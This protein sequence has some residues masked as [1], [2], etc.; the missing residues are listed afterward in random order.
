MYEAWFFTSFPPGS[1][2]AAGNSFNAGEMIFPESRLSLLP[3]LLF[4]GALAW[5]ILRRG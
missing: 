2:E 1:P 4:E 5:M 3:L